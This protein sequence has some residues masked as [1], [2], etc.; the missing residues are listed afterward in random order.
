MQ[1]TTEVIQNHENANVRKIGQ[2]EP[3]HNK[4]KKIKLGGGQAHDR[5]SG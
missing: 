2:D 3:R 5:S 1:A 4:C